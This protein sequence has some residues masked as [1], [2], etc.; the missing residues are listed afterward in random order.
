MQK[1]II[2]VA[3]TGIG[4]PTEEL[5]KIFDRFYRVE[6]ARGSGSGGSGLGLALIKDIV[7]IFHGVVRVESE[8]GSGSIF[9]VQLPL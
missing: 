1:L 5:D 4:I 6:K 7:S 2:S 8:V 9:T 3:D